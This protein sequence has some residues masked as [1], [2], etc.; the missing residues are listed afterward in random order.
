MFIF[1]TKFN[2][3]ILWKIWNNNAFPLRTPFDWIKLACDIFTGKLTNNVNFIFF[4]KSCPYK[5]NQIYLFCMAWIFALE[6]WKLPKH[7]FSRKLYHFTYGPG[8]WDMVIVHS[9]VAIFL[10]VRYTKNVCLVLDWEK[11]WYFVTKIVLTYWEK[12]MF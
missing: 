5:E 2:W 3:Y 11:K 9:D 4:M 8:L 7:I 12:K 1:S 6:T 10:N